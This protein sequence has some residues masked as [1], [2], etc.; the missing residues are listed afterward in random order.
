MDYKELL[1]GQDF[2]A[3]TKFAE[4]VWKLCS[5]IE[6]LSTENQA[7]R[8]AANGFKKQAEAALEKMKEGK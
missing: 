4:W 2:S 7:L 6:N 5:A 1:Q 3:P 8:N